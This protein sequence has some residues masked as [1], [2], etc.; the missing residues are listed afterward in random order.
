MVPAPLHLLRYRVHVAEAALEGVVLED[1]RGAGQ[2][3]GGVD[4]RRRALDRVRYG[5]A[6]LD[7]RV[8]V[9]LA[10]EGGA[11]AFFD[12]VDEEQPRALQDA[13]GFGDA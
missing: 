4:H 8:E 7:A 3:V 11:P 12:A 9:Q 10:G 1:R 6:L 5:Q 13:L 2:V